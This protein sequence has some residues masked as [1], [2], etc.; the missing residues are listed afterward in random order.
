MKSANAIT[1][2]TY[3]SA[4]RQRTLAIDAFEFAIPSPAKDK[5]SLPVV[6]R[7]STYIHQTKP[8]A[9]PAA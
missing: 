5:L 8:H 7:R 1:V 3:I 4:C 2:L 9:R 6:L